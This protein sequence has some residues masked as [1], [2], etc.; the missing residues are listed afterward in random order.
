M[1]QIIALWSQQAITNTTQAITSDYFVELLTRQQIRDMWLTR[2]QRC[3]WLCRGMILGEL[4]ILWGHFGFMY[5][6]LHVWADGSLM[7]ILMTIGTTLQTNFSIAL[8]EGEPMWM[9]APKW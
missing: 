5:K 6:Q 2:W 9:M 8:M 3:N 7:L 4:L 1:E